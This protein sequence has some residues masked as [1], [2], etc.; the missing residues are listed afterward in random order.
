[1][2]IYNHLQTHINV[3]D[4]ENIDIAGN[5]PPHQLLI[6][7]IQNKYNSEFDDQIV[8]D[9]IWVVQPGKQ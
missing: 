3:L 4:L 5:K 7:K 8:G 9:L 2:L 1:M 6:Q